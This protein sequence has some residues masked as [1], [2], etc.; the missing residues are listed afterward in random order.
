MDHGIRTFQTGYSPN[1]SVY[2]F[3][4]NQLNEMKKIYTKID[5]LKSKIQII[6]DSKNPIPDYKK[7]YH[8]KKR[9]AKL[10]FN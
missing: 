1:D 4:E 9:L 5:N 3:R 8:V 10:E 2:K 7:K 6:S